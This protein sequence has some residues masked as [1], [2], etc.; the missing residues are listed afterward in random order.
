VTLTFLTNPR[1][2]GNAYMEKADLQHLFLNSGM[3]SSPVDWT[4]VEG[5]AWTIIAKYLD[6]HLVSSQGAAALR[7]PL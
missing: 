1:F 5:V 2:T 4:K 6:L 7:E 3:G